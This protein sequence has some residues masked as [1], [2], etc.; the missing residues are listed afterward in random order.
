MPGATWDYVNEMHAQYAFHENWPEGMLCHI[1]GEVDEGIR[2]IGLW[3]NREVEQKY[4][5]TVALGVITDSIHELGP[6]PEDSGA[7][8]F[9][10]RE[11]AISRLLLTAACESFAD[12]GPDNDGSAIN[13]LDT[14]P[15][16]AT[17]D[18]D[19]RGFQ[20]FA[21]LGDDH[22]VPEG[23][24]IAWNSN[25]TSP[26]REHQ[27]W[28]SAEEASQHLTDLDQAPEIHP[29]KRISFGASELHP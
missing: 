13:A 8:N 9:E 19:A 11:S 4:F 3:T 2:S 29:L 24:I 10:P 22:A 23:L 28:A 14:E 7:E 26:A 5:R 16:I 17:L 12:I 21:F 27:V 18:S 15:V 1:T 6:P 25:G 20:P